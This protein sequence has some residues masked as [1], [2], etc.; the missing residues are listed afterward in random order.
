MTNTITVDLRS[1][2][3]IFKD[4][5]FKVFKFHGKAIEYY[6]NKG[7]NISFELE[8]KIIGI[9]TESGEELWGNKIYNYTEIDFEIFKAIIKQAEELEWYIDD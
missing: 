3:E 7:L 1:A 9:N 2:E 8:D 5:G 6:N 4:L